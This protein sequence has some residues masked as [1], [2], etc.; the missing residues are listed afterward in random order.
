M[1]LGGPSIRDARARAC[2]DLCRGRVPTRIRR[3][4]ERGVTLSQL[5]VLWHHVVSRCEAE[6]WMDVN[7][8]LLLAEDVTMYD[9]VRYVLKPATRSV[10]GK[11]S[12]SYVEFVATAPQQPSW[13]VI[14][15]WG[16]PFSGA[17]TAHA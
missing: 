14:H 8:Q 10:V 12:C 6:G 17:R 15:W 5:R 13:V 4:E 9:L 1:G 2:A 11:S 3:L 7:G 16:Q